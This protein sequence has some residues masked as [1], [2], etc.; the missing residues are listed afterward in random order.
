M[1]LSKLED[2]SD[3]NNSDPKNLPNEQQLNHVTFEN[4]LSKSKKTN[5]SSEPFFLLSFKDQP[6]KN[7]ILVPV[8]NDIGSETQEPM[9]ILEETPTLDIPKKTMCSDVTVKKLKPRI[10]SPV[11]FLS[12]T[13]ENKSTE[14]PSQ[15]AKIDDGLTSLQGLS[16]FLDCIFQN[17]K[18]N[19]KISLNKHE[20]TILRSIVKRKFSKIL[21][22]H[23][24]GDTYLH[25]L[26]IELQN[27]ISCK[28]PEEN[29]KFI[30]KRCLKHM[31]EEF[32]NENQT[33]AKRKDIDR[34][35]YEYYF[36]SVS[37]SSKI[38]ID[39]FYHPKNS[40]IKNKNGPKTINNTYI[41]NICRSK[42]F[43]KDFSD[44]LDKFLLKEYQE[45][46]KLKIKN[47]I[48]RWSKEMKVSTDRTAAVSS[49]CT[50]IEKNKKCKLPWSVKEVTEAIRSVN[51]L[52][53]VANTKAN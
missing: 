46:I 20:Q 1:G 38:S 44:Y 35:F 19:K 26:F 37:D 4:F 6:E 30:F 29:Y 13:I 14:Q 28:R 27:A 12:P 8:E 17:K 10:K 7:E 34:C 16:E 40:K 48:A 11:K 53:E 3:L 5:N 52:F 31:K 22:L 42:G 23:P 39:N 21:E 50:Y 43:K 47:L 2:Y 32:K 41:Q 15:N 18:M 33:L 9:N 24:L 49:I 25:D 51:V 36:R 45:S